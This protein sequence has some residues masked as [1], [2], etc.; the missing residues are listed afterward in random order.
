MNQDIHHQENVFDVMEVGNSL[1][2][3]DIVLGLD[4]ILLDSIGIHTPMENNATKR[5]RPKKNQGLNSTASRKS[6]LFENKEK[7]AKETWK[8]AKALG[9]TATKMSYRC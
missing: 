7:E 8:L 1:G 3:L 6:V 5:G 9:A 4:A 2:N